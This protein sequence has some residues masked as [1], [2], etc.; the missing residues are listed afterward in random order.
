VVKKTGK[1]LQPNA[2]ERILNRAFGALIGLGFGL[3]HNYL[4]QVRGRKTGRIYSAPINLLELDDRLYL[5]CPR[6]RAQWVRNAE[7]QGSIWLKK[8]RVREF[9]VRAVPEAQ[10]P[11]ILKV[12]LDHFKTTVQRYFPV[13]AGSPASAFAA[14]ATQYPVF[15]LQPI[16]EKR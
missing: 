2:F 6:G 3:R 5:V 7:S 13:K 9:K 15:E 8:R 1:F 12:Y 10:K 16:D 11:G 14:Y 4:L